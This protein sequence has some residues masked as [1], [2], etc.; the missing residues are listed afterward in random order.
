[1]TEKACKSC[2][3][4]FKIENEDLAFLETVSPTFHSKKFQI[5]APLLCPKCRQ[6]R[7][8]LFRNERAL[9]KRKCD[10]SGK[11]MVSIY[12]PDKPYTVYDN[13]VWWGDDWDPLDYGK[14]FDFSRPFFEQFD[15]L[16]KDVPKMSRVQQGENENSEYTN[17]ASNNKNCYLIFSSNSSEDCMYGTWVQSSKDCLD[18][19]D[20]QG[21]ELAYE[22]I[23]C[24]NCYDIQYCQKLYNSSRAR[25][26]FDCRNCNNIFACVGL[27][28]KEY[29]ILNKKVSKE[30]FENLMQNNEKKAE[31]LKKYNDLYLSVPRIYTMYLNSENFS[32][33]NVVN[34][35]NVHYC[36]DVFNLEDCK[37]CHNLENSKTCYDICYYGITGTNER[38]Y[39]VEGSG[40]GIV[41][42]LFSKMVWGGCIDIMYSYECFASKN[43]FGCTGLKR[44]QYC[45]LNKKY[46]KEDYEKIVPKIIEHMK[47][48]GE[49]GEYFNPSISPFGYN[50]TV[51]REF[52]PLTKEKA[53]ERGYKWKDK[54][55]KEYQKAHG[56]ILACE[57]CSKNYKITPHEQSFYNKQSIPIPKKCPDCRHI[58][59]VALRGAGKL[60]DRKC[61][62]CSA[63][64]QTTYSPERPEKVYCEACY[65]KAID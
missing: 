5:P 8:L 1:M 9:Y 19:Y 51:A 25:Y 33:N 53:L 16:L 28:N 52:F 36:N 13:E 4:Q 56:D 62:E 43:L 58:Q 57:D 17:C 41:N 55:P 21:C 26:C 10:K 37:Y 7:R 11:D 63:D 35:K 45:I 48:T 49:W 29:F 34:C 50:E 20:L 14:D 40:H 12:S 42:V 61:N 31:V 24:F 15:E 54:D 38:L 46:P 60:Y 30:E 47:K 18:G 44:A 3:N 27:R 59:R 23:D 22:C 6:Q 32:G 39:E 65:L 2:N 64:I